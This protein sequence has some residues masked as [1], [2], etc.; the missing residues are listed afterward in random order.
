V[1]VIAV[2]ASLVTIFKVPGLLF[3]TEEAGAA[4]R[5]VQ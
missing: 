1:V 5:T 2:N 4:R 3:E